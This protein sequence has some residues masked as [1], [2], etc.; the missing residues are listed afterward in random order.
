MADDTLEPVW[1]FGYG[2]LIFKQDFPSL[3]RQP[4]YIKG[5]ERRFW[6]GSHDHRGMPDAP[7]RVVTLISSADAICH[8]MAYRVEPSVLAHLDYREK[9]GYRR[10]TAPLYFAEGNTEPG[11]V[12]LATEDNEAYLG[13]APLSEIA[14]HIHR[15][16][17]PSG[18]NRDYLMSLAAALRQL[19]VQDEHVYKLA[20]LVGEID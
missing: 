10:V 7:G 16:V 4:A 13:P 5:W 11:I 20:A 6:Q 17:G 12:Y 8:G 2:S 9:N 19:S 18:S 14:R 3:D 1:I 15:S